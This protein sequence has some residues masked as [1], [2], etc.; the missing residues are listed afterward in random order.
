LVYYRVIIIGNDTISFRQGIYTYIPE[1][2]NV[3]KEYNVA[4]I[5]I[6][7]LLLLLLLLGSVGGRRQSNLFYGFTQF[8]AKTAC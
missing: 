8:Q 5:L 3:P 1:T 7:L 6:L 4:T 2:N